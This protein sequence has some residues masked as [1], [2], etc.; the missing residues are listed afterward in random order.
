MSRP[1]PVGCVSGMLLIVVLLN[2]QLAD[3]YTLQLATLAFGGVYFHGSILRFKDN[4]PPSQT[5]KLYYS[6]AG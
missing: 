6:L 5:R 4:I 2:T 3:M 1:K